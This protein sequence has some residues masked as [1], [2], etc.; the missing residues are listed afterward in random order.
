MKHLIIGSGPA[1]LSAAATLRLT[2]PAAR[3]TILSREAFPP[4]ARMALPYLLAGRIEEKD[5][6]LTP[7][8][9]AEI[10]L[11]KEAVR[12]MPERKE[13]ETAGGELFPYDRLLI[14]S[15]ASPKKPKIPGVDLPFVITVR[16]LR[17]VARM[18]ALLKGKTGRAL[19]AGAG[20]VGLE[21]GDAL[22]ELGMAVTFVVSS[23]HILSQM[24]DQAAAAVVAGR[25]QEAG[26]EILT[27]DDIAAIGE[28]GEVMLRSGKTR[29]CDLVI[30]GKGVEPSIAFLAGS[31]IAIDEGIAVN[32]RMETNVPGAYAAGDAAQSRDIV[33]GKRRVNALW[34]VAVEQG[35][36]AALNMVG[37]P[38]ASPGS[39]ARNIMHVFG[40]SIFAAG[41]GRAEQ[42]YQPRTLSG[43]GFYRKIVLDGRVLRGIIA[44]G[45][46]RN[47]GFYG[48]LI[49]R[50]TDVAAYAGSIL[51][52]T[53]GY[54]R[55]LARTCRLAT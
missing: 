4:Y 24:L 22:H 39:F 47:E 25:L 20:P 6:L 48:G 45:E 14:A 31:G 42:G 15:G 5:L 38:A 13:V 9:G 18:Q 1:A 27:G 30:F 21:T 17:D 3:V 46:V 50:E 12:V 54:G 41:A 29:I 28:K 55:H 36:V 37:I 34:P 7:P 23:S 19:L 35:R 40:L 32:E 16:D 53:Y 51:K 26:V 33:S 44:V 43:P 52:G 2:D 11:G 8:A 10:L 49:E